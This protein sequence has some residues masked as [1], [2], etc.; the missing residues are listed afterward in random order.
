MSCFQNPISNIHNNNADP[1]AIMIAVVKTFCALLKFQ[2]P[3]F[4]QIRDIVAIPNQTAGRFEKY[5][6]LF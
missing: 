1:K 6:S 4:C 5:F 2:A 3:I